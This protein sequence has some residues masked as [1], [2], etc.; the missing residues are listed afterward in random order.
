MSSFFFFKPMR[1]RPAHPIA[2]NK[3]TIR[4]IIKEKTP[5]ISNLTD[6]SDK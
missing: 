6:F 4:D 5:L 2:I 1:L 3:G